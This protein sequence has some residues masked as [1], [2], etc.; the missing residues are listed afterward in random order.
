MRKIAMVAAFATLPLCVQANDTYTVD[1]AHSYANFSILHLGYS[2]LHGRIHSTGGTFILDPDAGTGSV[3][4]NLD[5]ATIDTGHQERDEHLRSPDFLSV[6][7]FPEMSFESTSVS[8]SE[9]GGTIEGELT[10]MGQTKPIS[11]EVTRWNCGEHPFTQKATCGFD[12]TSTINRSDF[13][14]NY[15]S[16]GIGDELTLRIGVEGSVEG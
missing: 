10:L 8:L 1:P 15:G 12:A 5:P 16:P 14:V 3:Q 6:E 9:E 4:V 11:L 13:G 7:E 2:T